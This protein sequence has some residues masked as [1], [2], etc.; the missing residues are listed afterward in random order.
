MKLQVN[1]PVPYFLALYGFL[2]RPVFAQ[3]WAHNPCRM[4]TQSHCCRLLKP[5]PWLLCWLGEFEGPFQAP[6]TGLGK[7]TVK[8]AEKIR[9]KYHE[10]EMRKLVWQRRETQGCRN[11]NPRTCSIGEDQKNISR[12]K[13]W[14]QFVWSRR[15]TSLAH[16]QLFFPD[17]SYF[18][19][20]ANGCYNFIL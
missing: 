5:T 1:L 17:G 16:P 9:Y 6:G 14:H 20:L 11:Q 10:E 15:E 7:K 8:H 13:D 12:G 4:I 18:Y 3:D 2:P 19:K